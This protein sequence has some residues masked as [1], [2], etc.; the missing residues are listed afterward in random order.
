MTNKTK[1]TEKKKI[2]LQGIHFTVG[3]KE[4]ALSMDECKE[5]KEL[6]VQLLGSEGMTQEVHHHHTNWWWSAPPIFYGD[7]RGG[8]VATNSF[9]GYDQ[10]VTNKKDVPV[11]FT[12]N[13]TDIGTPSAEIGKDAF[14]VTGNVTGLTLITTDGV[15]INL[16]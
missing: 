7:C 5:L 11:T 8:S 13:S 9:E 10:G 12:S 1:D 15:A 3:R 4:I 14:M 6:L 2:A 16:G